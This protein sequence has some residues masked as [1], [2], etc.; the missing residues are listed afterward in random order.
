MIYSLA[1]VVF[2]TLFVSALL[3]PPVYS[4]LLWVFPDFSPP[5]SRV[6]DRVAMLV[7]LIFVVVLRRS[8]NLGGLKNYCKEIKFSREIRLALFGF[9]L[10]LFISALMAPLIIGGGK[11]VWDEKPVL[12]L[13]QKLLILIPTAVF[14]SFLEETFFRF[15]LFKN[16]RARTSI[17]LA[18]LLT[19]G[20][21]A[22]AH[23]IA[24][25]KS[26][27]YPGYELFVG[28][29]YLGLVAARVFEPEVLSIFFGLFLV[30]IV[31]AYAFDKTQSL[32]LC[33]GLHAGW[34]V[35]VKMCTYM[36]RLE[37]GVVFSTAIG[38]RYVLVSN[39]VG[40]CAVLGVILLLA[41]YLRISGRIPGQSKQRLE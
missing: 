33:I 4:A 32:F 36:T 25:Q 7:I 15:L 26:Y 11:L 14:I 27:K 1:I 20:V 18:Y 40:W 35:A 2:G 19:S 24:P 9:T 29:E 21:Y 16:L 39:P 38:R 31:L 17:F 22:L 3:T 28:F 30:G 8:F 5:F 34:I 6:F 23:I 10:T 41:F 12:Y 13:V 37:E